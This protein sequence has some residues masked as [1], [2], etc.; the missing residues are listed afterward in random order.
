MQKDG[1]DTKS[2]TPSYAIY[3]DVSISMPRRESWLTG[4]RRSSS[5]IVAVS[6]DAASCAGSKY[7]IKPD[8][9]CHTV[10]FTQ[11]I[12]TRRLVDKNKIVPP[13]NDAVSWCRSF[14]KSGSVCIPSSQVCDVHSVRPGEDCLSIAK[15][16]GKSWS[17]I[18][19]WNPEVGISCQN[20]GNYI[21]YEICASNPGGDW[22]NPMPELQA[23]LGIPDM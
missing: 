19:S 18:V 10:S 23:P 22:V 7:F 17:Q 9:N 12:S 13:S 8:D 1:H 20:L 21:G 6:S 4:N 2:R 5:S 16:V 3:Y 14:P 15:A 11:K